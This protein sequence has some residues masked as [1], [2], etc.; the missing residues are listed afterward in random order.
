MDDEAPD[1]TPGHGHVALPRRA[2]GPSISVGREGSC[3][4]CSGM[5][6]LTQRHGVEQQIISRGGASARWCI[7]RRAVLRIAL[8]YKSVS[9]IQ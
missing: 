7:K 2:R 4:T 8:D 6:P 1:E 5:L 9:V 3:L